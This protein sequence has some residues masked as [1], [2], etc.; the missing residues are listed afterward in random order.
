MAEKMHKHEEWKA[1]D[2]AYKK[3]QVDK[4]LRKLQCGSD[5]SSDAASTCAE[6]VDAADACGGNG[7]LALS[8]QEEREARKIFK[9]LNDIERLQKEM[10]KGISLDKLQLEKIQ[11]KG[12][13]ESNLVMVKIRAGAHR[14][15]L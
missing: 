11:S 8:Q 1:K 12:V 5:A 15:G 14:P 2:A 9:K 13:L 3:L 7:R 4:Q 6:T 10:D